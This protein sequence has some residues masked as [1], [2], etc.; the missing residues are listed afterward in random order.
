MKRDVVFHKCGNKEIV[1]KSSTYGHYV[2]TGKIN[3]K[4]VTFLIDT[5][6]SFVSIPGKVAKNLHQEIMGKAFI[7]EVT[8]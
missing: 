2:V 5:G 1:L 6:A 8:F 7:I 3:N 4:D